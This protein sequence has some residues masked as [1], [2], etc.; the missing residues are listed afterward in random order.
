MKNISTLITAVLISSTCAFGQTEITLSPNRDV[1]IGYHD[2]FGTSSN[3]YYDAAQFAAYTIPG[4]SGGVNSNRALVSFDLSVIPANAT[5]IEANLYL[6][7]F[8]KFSVS[9]PLGNG[10]VGENSASFRKITSNWV[11]TEVTWDSQPSTTVDG[12]IFL[13]KST[14]GYEDYIVDMTA[15]AQ[16]MYDNPS[17]NLG[18]LYSLVNESPTASLSFHSKDSPDVEKRPKL[19]IKY[20]INTTSLIEN[21]KKANFIQIKIFPNPTSSEFQLKFSEQ[22]QNT[23]I[24]LTDLNGK[25]VKTYPS[26]SGSELHMNI[27]EL[28]VGTYYVRI[29]ELAGIKAY[30]II[31]K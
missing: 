12:E 17:E 22:V 5:I 26:F 21:N 11:E 30:K 13:S 7:A 8:D 16:N 28:A 24:L 31:K 23:T 18:F 20:T 3:N 29:P 15:S 2:G 1:A 10:H 27:Q 19:I 9:T 6:Y 4:S 14:S 25:I